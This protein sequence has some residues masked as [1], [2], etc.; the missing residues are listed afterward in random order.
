[1]QSPGVLQSGLLIGLPNFMLFTPCS[2]TQ[3]PVK[4]MLVFW[5]VLSWGRIKYKILT[6]ANKIQS[7]F[8][9]SRDGFILAMWAPVKEPLHLLFF[10]PAMIS[11]RIS[12][13]WYS[14]FIQVCKCHIPRGLGHPPYL[15]L[16]LI[17]PLKHSLQ[18]GDPFY[19]SLAFHSLRA[20][21]IC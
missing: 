10:L 19:F 21:T 5:S 17:P 13:G 12:N 18:A 20:C 14:H 2:L 7:S 1:M 16:T 8:C 6:V 15:R 11:R 3:Q 4:R 9:S